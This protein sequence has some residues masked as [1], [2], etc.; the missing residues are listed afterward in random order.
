MERPSCS[1][2]THARFT[3]PGYLKLH[4]FQ[5]EGV[6]LRRIQLP[7]AKCLNGTQAAA[8][9]TEIVSTRHTTRP[10]YFRPII[11]AQIQSMSMSHTDG[12]ARQLCETFGPDLPKGKSLSIFGFIT[13]VP[14][15]LGVDQALDL[16]VEAIC[17]AHRAL[18]K[19]DNQRL[20]RSR[21]SYGR[22]LVK[23]RQ[24][25]GNSPSSSETLCAAVLLGV[26]EVRNVLVG[27]R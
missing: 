2:C 22:A 1:K 18:L 12:L 11:E 13:E 24:N 8:W 27:N 17:I 5:D 16:S 6:K 4:K 21:A 19:D 20:E 15:R 7:T 10:T 3:C 14:S 9:S 23:L 26:Y 25:L